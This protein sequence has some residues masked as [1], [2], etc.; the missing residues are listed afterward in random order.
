MTRKTAEC[1]TAVF[2]YI[3][4][5]VFD[6]KPAIIMTDWESAM[7][8]AIRTSFP[9]SVLKGC[10]YH[11]CAALRKK[12]ISFG[13]HRLLKKNANARLIKQMMFSLQL[14]PPE[15]FEEGYAH[16][17]RLAK[18]YKLENKFKLFFKYYDGYWISQVCVK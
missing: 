18:E 14:L 9:G 11:Y 16:V 5:Y 7:R 15:M 13:L 2:N 3:K 10:W 4:K 12:L 17:K 6:L 8:C 1:Y